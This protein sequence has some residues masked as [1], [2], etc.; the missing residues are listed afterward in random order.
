M[1]KLSRKALLVAAIP[2][3]AG[4]IAAPKFVQAQQV[5]KPILPPKKVVQVPC[6]RCL[7]GKIN[8]I[9]INTGTAPWRLVSGPGITTAGPA[10]VVTTPNNAWVAG[11][12]AQWISNSAS[13]TT[14]ADAGTYVYELPIQVPNCVIPMKIKLNGKVA[15]DNGYQAVLVSPGNNETTIGSDAGPLSF[16][17]PTP[18]SGSITMSGL[19][20]LRIK[21][22]NQSLPQALLVNGVLTTECST[23]LEK[24]GKAA[25]EDPRLETSATH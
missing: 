18:I 4:A 11:G 20:Y 1:F 25:V 13:G 17:N 2:L 19:H 12:S 9:N 15:A 16:Q 7:D 8:T 24:D 3:F 22:T 21:V 23:K 14:S 5:D 10:T 6:C